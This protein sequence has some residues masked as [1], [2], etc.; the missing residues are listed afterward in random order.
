MYSCDF[1]PCNVWRLDG[2][3][4]HL[5]LCSLSV[6]PYIVQDFSSVKPALNVSHG[7]AALAREPA[8]AGPLPSGDDA[9]QYEAENVHGVY[10]SIAP[11]FAATRYA[12]WPRVDAFLASLPSHALVADVGCGNGKYLAAAGAAGRGLVAVGTDR[13]AGLVSFAAGAVPAADAAV[14]DARAQPFRSGVFDA[15]VN[16][17]VVHHFASTAR[18]VDA[19]AETVR[20]LR[21]GGRALFYVWA[22]DRPNGVAAPVPRHGNKGRKML[23]R[24]FEAQDMLVP[25][26]LRR[27]K[28]GAEDERVLGETE[29]VYMRFYHVYSQGELETELSQVP[30]LR[31]VEAF[32]DH[33]NWCAEVER[34]A[35]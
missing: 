9:E 8:P 16:I 32:F 6:L 17:A 30:S 3:H 14:A 28:N 2:G 34:I 26:H 1:D 18:R 19:W 15:A 7:M 11:H 33:Q 31:V 13:C 27:K 25:W 20:L 12:P 35:E 29:S 10:D 22:Q 21:V 23:E 4:L 24:R 5:L